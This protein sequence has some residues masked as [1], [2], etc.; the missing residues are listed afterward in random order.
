[1]LGI[2]QGVGAVVWSPLAGG[3]L[4]GRIDRD[5]PPQSGTRTAA[6]GMGRSALPLEQFYDLIDAL[7]D[8]ARGIDRTVSHVALNCA[9]HRRTVS[10]LVIGARNE[11]QLLEN[12]NAAE[13]RLTPDQVARLDAASNRT[14]AYPYWHQ[15]ALFLERNPP[16]V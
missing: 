9:L 2:D 6:I 14:P 15:R 4:S 1:P 3:M 10:T 5:H 8:V 13:F 12:L 7:R 16:P 11:E